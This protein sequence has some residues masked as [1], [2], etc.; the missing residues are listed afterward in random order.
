MIVIIGKNG[1]LAKKCIEILGDKQAIALG[2]SDIDIT[3]DSAFAVLDEIKP[4]AIINA[5]AYTAVD[6]AESERE[7]ALSINQHAV[8]RLNQYCE[9]NDIH[10]VHISTDYVFKGDKGSAYL[11]DDDYEPVNIYGETKMLGEKAILSSK[12]EKSCILRTSWVYSEFGGNFVASMLKFMEEK[13]QLGIICD[14]IG[15]PTSADTLARACILASQEQLRGVHHVTDE[16]VASWYDFAKAI[17]R[18]AYQQG[19]ISKQ[20]PIKPISTNEYPTPA[21]RPLYS[22]L[23]KQSLKTGLP[24]LTLPYWQEALASVLLTIQKTQH[25]TNVN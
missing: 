5:S 15:T 20:I 2:R 12:H 8:A 16:G 19:L 25:R 11:P 14:Q 13:E 1:Q 3:S 9:K 18:I 17:Q 7:Q 21:K 4:S 10:F 22:V 23:S 6:K 24:T